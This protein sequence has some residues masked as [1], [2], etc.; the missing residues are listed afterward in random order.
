[1]GCP[2]SKKKKGVSY[3]HVLCGQERPQGAWVI[4]G[5]ESMEIKS[6]RSD[7]FSLRA[8]TRATQHFFLI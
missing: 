6:A 2:K 3:Q 1:M 4:S 7:M 8:R 5:D